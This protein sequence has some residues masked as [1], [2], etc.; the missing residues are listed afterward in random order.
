MRSEL[1]SCAQ[2]T[3]LP[4][5]PTLTPASVQSDTWKV[6]PLRWE[7][8]T[9]LTSRFYVMVHDQKT[10]EQS[11]NQSLKSV[12]VVGR[13]PQG[14]MRLILRSDGREVGSFLMD[15]EGRTKD[16][17]GSSQGPNPQLMSGILTSGNMW[18]DLLVSK[19]PL[20]A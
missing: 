12:E 11:T 6:P 17:M 4:P 16:W 19:S 18:W 14:L 1:A 20:K 9:K 5:A 15:G 2:R 7:V 10:G 13:T 8:G 3:L